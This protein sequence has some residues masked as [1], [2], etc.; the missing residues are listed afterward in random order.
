[1]FTTIKLGI[2]LVTL[3]LPEGC[4]WHFLFFNAKFLK[5]LVQSPRVTIQP[6]LYR[7][8]KLIKSKKGLNLQP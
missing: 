5:T 2:I 4:F 3:K 6:K 8:N 7:I 1:M